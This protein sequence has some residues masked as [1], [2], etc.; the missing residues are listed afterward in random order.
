[1]RRMWVAGLVL[2]LGAAACG[3][4]TTKSG[5][6]PSVAVRD[7]YQLVAA[8]ADATSHAKT[9]RMD[10]SISESGTG[11]PT[12]INLDM[13]GAFAFDGS[14]ADYTMNLGSLLPG[15]ARTRRSKC[16]WW[17]TRSTTTWRRSCRRW[18]SR[19]E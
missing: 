10:M 9:A 14:G 13:Q 16:A 1:M 4:S 18:A 8:S 11:L 6:G 12:G 5:Q 19:S 2:V 17:T 3:T 15:A 7:P